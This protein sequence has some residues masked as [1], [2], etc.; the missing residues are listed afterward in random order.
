MGRRAV[1]NSVRVL[2][3]VL[4]VSSADLAPALGRTVLWRN[5]I[6]RL[7]AREPEQGLAAARHDLP[8]LIV[9]D[10]GLPGAVDLLH[11]LRRDGA[12]RRISLAAIAVA[13]NGAETEP[14]LRQAGANLVLPAPVDPAVW[15][16]RLEELLDVPPRRE[17]RLYAAFSL[18]CRS[19]ADSDLLEALVLNMSVRGM[20]I[21]TREA[22]PVGS[23]V[24]LRLT[25]P[26]DGGDSVPLVGLV[27]RTAPAESGRFRNGV[28]FLILR[29]P[30]RDRLRTY[31]E[32]EAK[33]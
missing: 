10:G 33:E 3:R 2:P 12:T 28:Q 19:D 14:R 30:V 23:T 18:W 7:F 8:N 32:A 24:D 15:D 6:D 1:I 13:G 4:I 21:E 27:V 17:S 31:I 20:L 5:G 26:G 29:D 25:L 11:T 9:V 16:Q 22:L